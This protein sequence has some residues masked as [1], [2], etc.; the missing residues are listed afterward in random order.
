MGIFNG[1]PKDNPLHYGEAYSLWSSLSMAKASLD[2]YQVY[3]NHTG[4][5]DL[6][7]FLK[8]VINNT[9]NPAIKDLEEILL[10]NDIAV[11]PTPAGRPEADI[12][13]IPVGSRL[14]DVQIAYLVSA[15]IAAGLTSCSAAISQSVREDVGLLFAQLSAKKIKDGSTLLELMK[16]KGWLIVPPLLAD[17]KQ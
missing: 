2:L 7:K 3:D 13:Q 12:E 8:Q 17:T 11:P 14:Q 15:D 16:D 9:V 4:D 10:Q 5:D 6:K 1:N